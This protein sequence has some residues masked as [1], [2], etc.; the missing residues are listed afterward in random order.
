[1]KETFTIRT[2]SIL[3]NFFRKLLSKATFERKLSGVSLS[4]VCCLHHTVTFPKHQT[5][6]IVV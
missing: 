3:E 1:L 2:C 5:M 4:L 6:A